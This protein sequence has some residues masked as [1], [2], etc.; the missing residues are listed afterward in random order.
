MSKKSAA[1]RGPAGA[2]DASSLSALERSFVFYGS[3]H[4][5][6]V[7]QAVH[8]IFVPLIVL[9]FFTLLCQVPLGVAAPWPESGLLG[10]LSGA[11]V[12][13]GVFVSFYL[14]LAPSALGVSASAGMVGLYLAGVALYSSAALGGRN[15][16]I[17]IGLN[18]LS[19]V[20]QIY[21]HQV[22]ERRSPAFLD[23]LF[24]ALF[25]AP[26]FVFIETIIKVGFLADLDAKTAP[27]I[28][29]NIAEFR[30]KGGAAAA[31]GGGKRKE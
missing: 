22:H 25:M 20:A 24:Q 17:A 8:I 6:A 30:S 16:Y 29:A 5:D 9:T 10:P 1:A 23:N 14:Y 7:N 21:A 19:W 2:L 13:L 27:F 28:A 26:L 3:Y 11:T 18:V 4:S 15:I 12:L 31:E